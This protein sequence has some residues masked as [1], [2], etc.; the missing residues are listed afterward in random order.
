[1]IAARGRRIDVGDLSHA[2]PHT[3][4]LARP[5]HTVGASLADIERDHIARVLETTGWNR[6]SAA[7]VLGIDRRTLF[8]KI[9][10][11][12]LVGPLRQGPDPKR[13]I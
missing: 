1:L 5:E 11:Y 12:G 6:S 4:S 13:T 7:Q 8:A 2:K 10:R 9:R 3:P